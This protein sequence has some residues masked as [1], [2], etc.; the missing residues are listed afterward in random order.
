MI[1]TAVPC[2]TS[3]GVKT[4]PSKALVC[5]RRRAPIA[6]MPRSV[7]RCALVEDHDTAQ[8]TENIDLGEE[9]SATELLAPETPT[10][11]GPP[12]ARPL[13]ESSPTLRRAHVDKHPGTSIGTRGGT[14]LTTNAISSPREAMLLQESQRMR[15]FTMFAAAMSAVLCVLIPLLDGDPLATKIHLTATALSVVVTLT[16]RVILRD[17]TSY[18]PW[19]GVVAGLAAA[20]AVA[21]GF[22]FWGVASAVCLVVPI[23]VYFFALNE[24][25]A[26]A[27]LI[28]CYGASGHALLSIA[29]LADWIPDASLV[30]PVHQ[31]VFSDVGMLLA[32][33][34]AFL[35]AFIMARALRKASFHT[36][37]QL[38]RAVRN[39][40]QRE[41]LLLEARDEL[42]RV[43]RVGDPGRFT[44]QVLGSYSLGA[45]LGRGAMG[46]VY[47][48]VHT[49]TG[50][51]AAVKLLNTEAMR[52]KELVDRFYRELD[53]ASSLDVENV[54]R[55]LEHA[56]A[57]A[58]LPYLA[59]ERLSG[60]TLSSML[61][62]H[63]PMTVAKMMPLLEA[64][65]RGI[66]AAHAKGIVHRDLKPQNIFAHRHGG[67]VV[68]KILDFGVSKLVSQDGTLT[69]GKLVGT[70]SYMAPEQA[71]A[72]VVDHRADL[73][74]IAVLLYRVVTGRPA[75]SGPSVPAIMH[76]VATTM[77]PKPS[78][79]AEIGEDFDVV[80]AIGMAKNPSDRFESGEEMSQAFAAAHKGA[81][82]AQLRARGDALML[83]HPWQ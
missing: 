21:T 42:A 58:P 61:R 17:D 80:F 15:F 18:R 20:S 23:G 56:D 5:G 36:L 16:L 57:D 3:S 19:M 75:F 33:Q 13:R 79:L 73:Y 65:A 69:Q 22:Y 9:T 71:I 12:T 14:Y 40:A 27:L 55:V 4:R 38:D 67:H 26:G 1:G 37:E 66:D 72:A 11:G 34:S 8:P 41:A 6:E 48:A 74:S 44:E 29:Q 83:S 52:N 50:A 70:P 54:V 25:I 24:S 2:A 49:T 68:W 31:T 46:D 28:Y 81:L 47:E 59:M 64:L 35:G 63:G 39:I 7:Y 45:I 82:S 53:I 77:P 51:P 43:G 62:K 30:R 60:S 32:L 76:R 10:V 78:V